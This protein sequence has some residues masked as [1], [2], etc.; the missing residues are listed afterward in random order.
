MNPEHCIHPDLFCTEC[1]GKSICE[2]MGCIER[3]KT[4]R[5]ERADCMIEAVKNHLSPVP[6]PKKLPRWLKDATPAVR[7]AYLEE[8]L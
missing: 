7:R 8:Q 6:R 3:V 1:P 2:D 5:A 4:E